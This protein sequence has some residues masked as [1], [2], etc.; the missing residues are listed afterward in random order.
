MTSKAKN[1]RRPV[2]LEP[3]FRKTILPNGIRILT[4]KHA[5]NR[6]VACGI[7]VTKGTRDEAIN[8]AGLAHFVEHLVFKRTKRRSAYE[9]ARDMEAV[10]GDLNAFTSRESTCFVT[11]SLREDLGLSLDV[12]ADLVCRP[13]FDARDI[14]KEKSVVLQEIHMSDDQLED[15]IFDR[16]FELAYP[17]SPLGQPILG[18]V[19]SIESM[20]RST[21]LDFHEKIYLPENIIVTVTGNVDHDR[22][23][24][25]VFKQLRFSKNN[26]S[27]KTNGRFSAAPVGQG[28]GKSGRAG[29]NRANDLSLS[30]REAP[31]LAHF[32][33]AVKRPSE[34]THILMGM[35]STTF[36]DPLRFDAYIVNTLLGGGM[37]S[38]LFQKVR[39]EK[40]LA[41]SVY[42]QLSTYTDS[43]LSLV[44][45]G[46]E[47][48]KAP[49]VIDT[50]L[51]EMNRLRRDGI[52][53]SDLRLF[54]TQVLGQIQLG[55]DDIE[56]RM[57]SLGV[58]E[59]V[60]GRYRAVEDVM[61]EIESVSLDSVH[62]YIEKY[63]RQD[64]VGMLVMGPIPEQPMKR[65]LS[66]K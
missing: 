59:M 63:M 19:K 64:E 32:R 22:V 60:L 43:G 12:L 62:E 4:E 34:Q 48:K 38:R 1:G 16:Y 18:T 6:A 8:E 30:R 26:K 53:K 44:Y 10:G 11:H 37:T 31:T 52:S 66:E 23:V 57:N 61:R 55:A 54:K 41:Y 7:W 5:A 40:G 21:I 13:V 15:A 29:Q 65:W 46:T 51:K 35:P 49:Q 47:A 25:L 27:L 36:S 2:N 39:E 14:A 50:I 42:S 28:K 9:I 45:A 3:V 56:N 17:E 58:N 20:K 33:H 24:D